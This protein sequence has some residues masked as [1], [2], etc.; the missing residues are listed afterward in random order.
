MTTFHDSKRCDTPKK[1]FARPGSRG[2]A[3][4]FAKKPK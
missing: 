2:I 4:E 1:I 3:G